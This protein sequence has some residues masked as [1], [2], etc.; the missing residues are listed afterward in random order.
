MEP[1]TRSTLLCAEVLRALHGHVHGDARSEF[2]ALAAYDAVREHHEAMLVLARQKLYGSAFTLLRTMFDGCV[3]GLWAGYL[4]SDVE[5][6]AFEQG[7]LTLE[8]SKVLRRLR[9][10]DGNDFV[11]ILES[12]HERT[13]ESLN[14]YVHIG[15]EAVAGRLSASHIGPNYLPERVESFLMFA[16]AMLVVAVMEIATIAKDEQL[17]ERLNAVVV[18]HVARQA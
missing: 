16:D 2:V 8:P 15:H 11:H 3:V 18:G 1:I 10:K 4:A 6:D 12:F 9:A 7:R 17:R 13:K 14:S 5:L